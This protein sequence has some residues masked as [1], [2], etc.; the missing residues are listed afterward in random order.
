M[1]LATRI[2]AVFVALV[3]IVTMFVVTTGTAAAVGPIV[4][5]PTSPVVP[6][7]TFTGTECVN[8]TEPGTYVGSFVGTFDGVPFVDEGTFFYSFT[9]SLE[10]GS[11]SSGSWVMTSTA[12]PSTVLAGTH[13]LISFSVPDPTEPLNTSLFEELTVT[14]GGGDAAGV[15]GKIQMFA[16]RTLLPPQPGCFLSFATDGLL[17]SSLRQRL[18]R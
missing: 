9:Q 2:R 8:L 3:V 14:G 17:L 11:V 10:A 7:G 5:P 4:Q 15:S 6:W 16:T 13:I 18:I 12:D 1:R